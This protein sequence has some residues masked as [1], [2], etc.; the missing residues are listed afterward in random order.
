MNRIVMLVEGEQNKILDETN[1]K[2]VK[3]NG[4]TLVFIHTIM[5]DFP[6]TIQ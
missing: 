5:I 3:N 1:V 2:S 6:K 4:Y